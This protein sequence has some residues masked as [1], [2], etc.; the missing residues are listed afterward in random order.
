[1]GI[2]ELVTDRLSLLA[3]SSRSAA[4][5]AE[6]NTS[7]LAHLLCAYVPEDWPPR[8]DDDGRMA[9]EGFAF[10]RGLLANDEGLMG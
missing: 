4:A 6:G 2:P 9:R 1:M 7:E 3:V 5:A 10:V 8:I